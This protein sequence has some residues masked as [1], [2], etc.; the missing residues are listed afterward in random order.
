[1]DIRSL[2]E[3]EPKP[4]IPEISPGD[5]VR[6]RFKGMEGGRT[7]VFEGTVIG[8]RRGGGGVNLTVRQVFH[9]VGVERT[10]PLRSPLLEQ[11]EILQHSKVRRA[12]LYYLRELS[13]KRARLKV[14]ARAKE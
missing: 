4:D 7:Q 5:I 13:R 9:E 11:V 2:L 1:M 12:K 14:K 6:V 3:I 10:F 8:V